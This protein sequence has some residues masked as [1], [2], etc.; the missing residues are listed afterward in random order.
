ARTAGL[1][2]RMDIG[3]VGTIVSEPDSS[4]QVKVEWQGGALGVDLTRW[5]KEKEVLA[6]VD[7]QGARMPLM[8]W[9][10]VRI[11]TAPKGGSSTC[12][13]FSRYKLPR[14]T[15]LR[16]ILLGTRKD[17]GVR[18]RLVQMTRE[19]GFTEIQ[20]GLHLEFRQNNFESTTFTRD[21]VRLT[22]D[23]DTTNLKN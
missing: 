12:T 7:G 11:D 10:V 16:C 1:L 13:L 17:S 15:G 22:R 20:S 8:P 23:V 5:L 9:T 19:G 6:V 18:L 2:L 3:L 14:T 4:R 21:I